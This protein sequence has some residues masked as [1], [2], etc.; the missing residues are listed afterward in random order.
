MLGSP[1]LFQAGELISH[2]VETG[3]DTSL[4]RNDGEQLEIYCIFIYVFL[5]FVPEGTA[6]YW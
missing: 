5:S 6:K 1:T 3:F 4:L 2:Q